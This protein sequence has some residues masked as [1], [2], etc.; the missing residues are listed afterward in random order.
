MHLF[1]RTWG[2]ECGF[3]CLGHSESLCLLSTQTISCVSSP[4]RWRN[5]HGF[6]LTSFF[7]TQSGKKKYETKSSLICVQGFLFEMFAW[8]VGVTGDTFIYVSINDLCIKGAG[9]LSLS[10]A[11]KTHLF[12]KEA[13]RSPW[14]FPRCC[15]VH[16]VGLRS[17]INSIHTVEA[18]IDDWTLLDMCT[19]IIHTGSC[20][21][22]WLTE[23]HWLKQAL[24]LTDI[25][26]G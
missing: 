19:G 18:I 10:T 17:W 1:H 9:C 4:I 8:H 6:T 25:Q 13:E 11:W 15:V 23:T 20:T 22:H 26:H 2:W 3:S 7:Y 12:N 5:W 16:N 14:T 21:I 24:T